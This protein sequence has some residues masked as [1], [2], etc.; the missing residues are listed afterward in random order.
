MEELL[1]LR[2]YETDYGLQFYFPYLKISILENYDDAEDS[3]SLSELIPT[4]L[5][6]QVIANGEDDV[7]P[8]DLPKS[9]KP[10]WASFEVLDSK[11][12]PA[13]RAKMEYPFR[14]GS[15][16]WATFWMQMRSF[17]FVNIKSHGE[18]VGN[19]ILKLIAGRDLCASSSS[20]SILE[21]LMLPR[22]NGGF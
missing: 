7:R 20:T 6:N 12:K 10:R 17:N 14:P 18:F 16:D 19:P 3:R 2:K 11:N 4:I 9:V 1:L 15:P 21:R 13:Y 22:F 8:C 5:Q